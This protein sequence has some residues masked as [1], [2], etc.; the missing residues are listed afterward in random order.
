MKRLAFALTALVLVSLTFAGE[1]SA[2]KPERDVSPAD[3]EF[4]LEGL[5]DFDVLVQVEGTIIHTVFKKREVEVYP[6]YKATL[7]NL[8]TGESIDIVIPGPWFI[9]P[10]MEIGTGPW[11]WGENPATGEPGLFL[12]RGRWVQA[13]EFTFVG[14][15]VDLCA[16]LAP[17]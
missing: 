4:T 5:C 8:E 9:G 17:G 14:R 1:A 3:D 2:Q 10:T 16:E 12:I 13:E 6:N 7:T 15:V 11:L